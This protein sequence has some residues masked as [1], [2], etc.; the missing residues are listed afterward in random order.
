[1]AI[2]TE[3][4]LLDWWYQEGCNGLNMWP[5]QEARNTELW[6]GNLFKSKQC[7]D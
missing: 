4:V 2:Y 1:M 5:V 7:E 3:K 6:L